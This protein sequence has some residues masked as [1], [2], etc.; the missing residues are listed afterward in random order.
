MG[1]SIRANAAAPAPANA[2]ADNS[3]IDL[4]RTGQSFSCRYLVWQAEQVSVIKAKTRSAGI[5][6][7][8]AASGIPA[9]L[10][11]M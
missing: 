3:K 8:M 2:S 1:Q 10:P 9:S 11:I 6:A 4:R 7:S 5:E